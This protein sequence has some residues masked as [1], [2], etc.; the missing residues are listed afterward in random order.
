M[1]QF[2]AYGHPNIKATHRT[3]LEITREGDLT[4]QG[5]C[6]IGVNSDFD[7]KRIKE[8]MTHSFDFI[9]HIVVG[10]ESVSLDAHYNPKFSDEVELVVR[11]GTH[12]S[13]RTMGIVSSIAA[14]DLPREMVERMKDPKQEMV[15]LIEKAT[16]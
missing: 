6:I 9:M 15:I 14:I 4:P 11:R 10:D 5:D 1:L 7:I 3:T 16:L 13:D 8:F 12:D 2:K